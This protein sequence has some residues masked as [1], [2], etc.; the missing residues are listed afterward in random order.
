MAAGRDVMAVAAGGNVS[1]VKA[2]DPRIVALRS[3]YETT[4]LDATDLLPDPVA[5]FEVWFTAALE[6]GL[7]QPHAVVLATADHDGR[8][9]ARAVLL[10]AFDEDGFVFYTN[11]RS[12]KAGELR[13]NPRAAL[14]FL[15]QQLHRQVRIEGRVDQVPEKVSD[16]YFATRPR[17][18]QLAAAVSP[19][20]RVVPG[21]AELEEAL[22]RLD[23][24]Y[25]E[26]D[27]PRPAGWG[28]YRVVPDEVEF[29]QGRPHRLHDRLRYRRAGAKWV[30]ERLA[31]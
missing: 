5:Q 11:Y 24:R 9:S 13:A 19:Q 4:G 22:E 10:Q 15:W 23:A 25:P 6:V 20:S 7:E 17:G 1:G 2:S 8:P 3:D 18:A 21:R 16:A 12:R 14:V 31:P 30:V 29:W 27:V 28:G 26:G